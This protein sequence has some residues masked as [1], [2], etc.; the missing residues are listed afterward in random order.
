MGN[1]AKAIKVQADLRQIEAPEKV[2]LA[3]PS[4]FGNSIDILVNNAGVEPV[5]PILEV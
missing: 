2:V 3:T 4:A 1:G 5:K